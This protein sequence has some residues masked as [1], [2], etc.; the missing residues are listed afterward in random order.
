ML[1]SVFACLFIS[2]LSLV[3]LINLAL[4]LL[5]QPISHDLPSAKVRY[6]SLFEGLTLHHGKRPLIFTL[7]MLSRRLFFAL[8]VIFLSNYPVLQIQAFQLISISTIIYLI[9]VKPF[10]SPQ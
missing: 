7:I 8:T 9:L 3:F 1:D 6:G 10:E 5:K 2:L 4:A